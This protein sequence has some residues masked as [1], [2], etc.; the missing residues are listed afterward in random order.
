M[1]QRRLE[2]MR[3]SHFMKSADVDAD[4]STAAVTTAIVLDMNDYLY[5][6]FGF[7]FAA[8]TGG[9]TKIEVVA[10]DVATLDSADLVA[11]KEYATSGSPDVTLSGALDAITD[12]VWI[13]VSREDLME[14]VKDSIAAGTEVKYRYVGLR[15]TAGNADCEGTMVAVATGDR[16]FADQ[17]PAAT[18]A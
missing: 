3:A 16:Q 13:E 15:L 11:I 9:F 2:K 1:S 7:R 18:I 6:T 8:G 4:F 5:A 10:D 14:E 17:T 12:Q